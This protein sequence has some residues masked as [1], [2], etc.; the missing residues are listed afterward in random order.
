M[1]STGAR[2]VQPP[3]GH[4][5]TCLPSALVSA[6]ASGRLDLVHALYARAALLWYGDARCACC[7]DFRPQ[8]MPSQ[9][10]QRH[11]TTC[12]DFL[13]WIFC[14][15]AHNASL[16]DPFMAAL[17][18]RHPHAA[19]WI[20]AAGG[21][22]NRV[23]QDV[24]D[25]TCA[26]ARGVTTGADD[27]ATC[28]TKGDGGDD[29][30]EWDKDS[31]ERLLVALWCAWPKA[32]AIAMRQVVRDGD[33]DARESVA[34]LWRHARRGDRWRASGSDC[35]AMVNAA[36]MST[37]PDDALSWVWRHLPEIF[38]DRPGAHR[39]MAKAAALAGRV[40]IAI[41]AAHAFRVYAGT[42]LFDR[43]LAMATAGLGVYVPG[44]AD[45]AD[46]SDG[47]VD[48][49]DG[50]NV[51]LDDDNVDGHQVAPCAIVSGAVR[52]GRAD[53]IDTAMTLW[54]RCRVCAARGGFACNNFGW[55]YNGRLR[56]PGLDAGIVHVVAHYPHVWPTDR[57]LDAILYAGRV[58]LLDRIGVLLRPESARLERWIES[59]ARNSHMDA[60]RWLLT[61]RVEKGQFSGRAV[62]LAPA[63]VVAAGVGRL[64]MVVLLWP[65]VSQQK[66]MR[67]AEDV[68]NAA[69]KSKHAD[70]LAWLVDNVTPAPTHALWTA[71]AEH[72][73]LDLLAILVARAKY[74]TSSHASIAVA[75][76][77]VAC[78]SLLLKLS[79]APLAEG[80]S[81]DECDRPSGLAP[82]R[83]PKR[84][85]ANNNT[86]GPASA[87]RPT[88]SPS[89]VADALARGHIDAVDWAAAG[90]FRIPWSDVSVGAALNRA[91]DGSC[92]DAIMRWA[93]QSS[94]ARAELSSRLAPDLGVWTAAT[95]ASNDPVR[96]ARLL[97][98]C[99]WQAWG[100]AATTVAR[101]LCACPVA[102]WRTLDARRVID[103]D[104]ECF[105]NAIAAS[106]RV[107][108]LAW[109]TDERRP[110]ERPPPFGVTHAVTAYNNGHMGATAW[111]LGRLDKV[112]VADFVA[113]IGDHAL[114]ASTRA[115]ILLPLLPRT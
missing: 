42:V 40:D 26:Y 113:R 18:G 45:V 14:R 98:R 86:H 21:L 106:G 52:S 39:H 60:L 33:A 29:D 19:V 93:T 91:H 68:T 31:D 70:I 67:V 34:R 58:D 61:E 57:A 28:G 9:R 66:A 51:L 44:Y 32:A 1:A 75:H 24:V 6:A 115:Q 84:H 71:V 20:A 85:R 15:G 23:A 62:D 72:A 48:N 7:V 49:A 43:T 46:N 41:E 97:A 30:V 65:H 5:R 36:A 105:A 77:H 22:P 111:I 104:P 10:Q 12:A 89:Y 96:I 88:M 95:L 16:G 59:A 13:D 82:S 56:A 99:P 47:L 54:R 2:S 63:L 38:L 76:G 101:T 114:H 4:A 87:R 81:A 53:A 78:A 112:A 50:H 17:V 79:A 73:D 108:L 94:L 27:G 100:V 107:D 11:C 25:V 109:M 55:E 69:A 3:L 83:A 74:P 64:D 90:P 102:M 80:A 8:S 37:R 92:F 110:G 35:E 103:F